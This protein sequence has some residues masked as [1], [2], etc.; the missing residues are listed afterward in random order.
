M[1]EKLDFMVRFWQLRA[2]HEASGEALT[3]AERLEL[4]SLLRMM[5]TDQR[6]PERGPL[7]YSTGHGLPVQLTA[8]GGFIASE[9]RLVCADG[10]VL[11]CATPLRV[12]DSTMV[13]LADAVAGVEYTLPCVVAWVLSGAPSTMALRVDGSPSRLG[14]AIPMPGMWRSP[15]GRNVP[16]LRT[17]T[18]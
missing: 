1:I 2:R 9:L 16:R 11:S 14:F 17:S 5:A 15:L 13:R 3:A 18:E 12:G 7:P 8:P 4:L 10:I 6:L